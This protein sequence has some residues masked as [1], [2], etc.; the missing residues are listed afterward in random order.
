MLGRLTGRP[1]TLS[2]QVYTMQ[3]KGQK[4]LEMERLRSSNGDIILFN[5]EELIVYYYSVLLL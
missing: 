2:R 3:R 5:M 4:K 1:R